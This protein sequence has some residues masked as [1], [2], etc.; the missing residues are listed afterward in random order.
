MTKIEFEPGKSI[1]G[2]LRI[3][4]AE[5]NE[6]RTTPATLTFTELGV[7][8]ETSTAQDRIFGG[9]AGESREPWFGQA[10]EL[11]AQCLFEAV[12]G[13][14]TLTGIRLQQRRNGFKVETARFRVN[15]AVLSA[16]LTEIDQPIAFDK[17]Y[18]AVAGLSIWWAVS[19]VGYT[20]EQSQNG[21]VEG[22][23]IK[24]YKVPSLEWK[25]GE[26]TLRFENHWHS[27]AVDDD[28]M[29]VS[30]SFNISSEFPEPKLADAHLDE[31][32]KVRSLL[33]I[34]HGCAL[35]YRGH[36]VTSIKSL[37]REKHVRPGGQKPQRVTPRHNF[38]TS[39]TVRER[40]IPAPTSKQLQH[41]IL[42]LKD[43]GVEGLE[44]WGAKWSASWER[45][46]NPVVAA[47]SNEHPYVE[48]QI[49]AAGIFLDGWGP[50]IPKVEGEKETYS[51]GGKKPGPTF[52]TYVYRALEHSR[53][54]WSQAASSRVGLARAISHIYISI[55]HADKEQP[56]PLE[57]SLTSYLMLLLA[58]MMIARQVDEDGTLIEKYTKGSS[59]KQ[60]VQMPRLND[61]YIN[62][63]GNFISWPETDEHP[64]EKAPGSLES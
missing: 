8:L 63:N 55:K 46:I 64:K 49:L 41:P 26:A 61:V 43:I 33:V 47:L 54:D 14:L 22:M 9:L 1:S 42:L 56:N 30:Q 21:L 50:T 57:M 7:E 19:S 48:D 36:Q 16:T 11:P 35:P 37:Y 39:R 6:Q 25:Q 13:A 29:M 44:R 45:L 58:R 28:G 23:T 17:V 62:D 59:F 15:E 53:A 52:T 2:V 12:D 60:V 5:E 20:V 24:T 18:S 10:A 38:I 31:Q 27:G 51:T 32:W 34:L 3:Y 4:D 40:T